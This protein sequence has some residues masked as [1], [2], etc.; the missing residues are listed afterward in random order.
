MPKTYKFS[1]LGDIKKVDFPDDMTEEEIGVAIE[2]FYDFYGK[3]Q[4]TQPTQQQQ[5]QPT[6]TG[7]GD[8]AP[9]QP[10]QPA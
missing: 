8:L 5:Q 2:G 4:Q 10:I 1:D 6:Y 9:T 7:V 3:S